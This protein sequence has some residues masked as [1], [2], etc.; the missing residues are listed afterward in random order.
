MVHRSAVVVREAGVE[1]GERGDGTGQPHESDVSTS[2]AN[3]GTWAQARLSSASIISRAAASLAPLTMPCRA[4]ARSRAR[5]PI[6]WNS[7]GG[8]RRSSSPVRS[9]PLPRRR[10]P[11]S[12]HPGQSCR[13]ADV[14]ERG[15][16]VAVE[17]PHF[18]AGSTT[19][20]FKKVL[21]LTASRTADVATSSP[22]A[23]PTSSIIVRY[24][25][26]TS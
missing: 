14:G 6:A 9:S 15:L 18:H 3:S 21:A 13:G 20:L 11:S 24:S 23:T 10:S 2:G 19:R 26:K 7:S 4:L 8:R 1:L 5:S 22:R 12:D 25:L 16:L 17:D